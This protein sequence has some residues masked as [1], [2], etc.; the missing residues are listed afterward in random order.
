[1]SL[2]GALA[3]YRARLR[4]RT[5]LRQELLAAVGIGLGVGLLFASQVT[6]TSLNATTEQLTPSVLGH[7]RYELKARSPLG[8]P[9]QM[10]NEVARLPGVRSA[11]PVLEQEVDLSGPRGRELVELLATEPSDLRGVGGMVSLLRLSELGDRARS[12]ARG[13]LA[14]KRAGARQRTPLMVIPESVAH[15]IG[16]DEAGRAVVQ[17]GARTSTVHLIALNSHRALGLAGDSPIAFMPL[18]SA[19]SLTNLE[20]RLSRILVSA[21]SSQ[22]GEVRRGL[23][24]LSTTQASVEPVTV[25]ARVFNQASEPIRKSTQTFAAICAL[26]GFVF[27]Y[28]ATLLTMQLRRRFVGELRRLG[29]TR[30]TIAGSLLIDI[31]VLGATACL[32][33]LALGEVL[34]VVS[35]EG[36]TG[37]LRFAFPVRA[38]RI[39]S[40]QD[41]VLA[42]AAGFLAA[43]V[44]V[45]ASLTLPTGYAPARSDGRAARKPLALLCGG[46]TCLAASGL[47][48]LLSAQLEILGVGLLIVGALALLPPA[49]EMAKTVTT[50]ASEGSGSAARAIAVVELR[51]GTMRTRSVVI[52]AIVAIAV[53]GGVLIEGARA[54]LLGGLHRSA[55]SISSAADLWVTPYGAQNLLA[56][57][58]ITGV[59][60]DSLQNIPGVRSVGT[61]R[62]SF[63]E[64]GNRRVWIVAPSST[65]SSLIAS[66]Q[67]VT[68][69]ASTANAR[70]REGGWTVVSATLARQLHLEVG[71][72]L[73]LPTPVP[74]PLR[75]AALSTNLGWS[76]GTV[77]L[78]TG[79]YKRAM[80][81]S[82]P[83]AFN[84]DLTPG[85]DGNA[86]ARAISRRLAVLGASGL[87]V[88]SADEREREQDAAAGQG[89]NRL[90]QIAFLLLLT[91]VLATVISMTSAI[92]Q[93]RYRFARLK[94]HGAGWQVL[95]RAL[96]WETLIVIGVGGICGAVIGAYGQIVLS[97]ALLDG[98]GY[99]VVFSLRPGVALA[100]L[101]IVTSTAGTAVALTG[102]RVART[103]AG[104]FS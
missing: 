67:M 81:E 8:F 103:A 93:R 10:V 37:F 28:C 89:L 18:G 1:V 45:L 61:F 19:Q 78:D 21:S 86:V 58:P 34:S 50:R 92:S 53:L 87:A 90:T 12:T 3:L 38:E 7:S 100:V 68:G 74:V 22:A 56:T 30:R 66:S 2:I 5:M 46:L 35:F 27:A 102:L 57:V 104:R 97:R 55:A 60:A 79:D 54:G 44:G 41:V 62:S 20:G 32:L 16:A 94:I 31:V 49:L 91:G 25:D 96:L 47:A 39:V 71:Q 26:L 76:P 48:V 23:E 77:M 99:P 11:V 33:G 4:E 70:L 52:A 24:S 75:V 65:A 13:L 14:P 59:A 64:L 85:A 63:L 29:A 83:T 82:A 88:Q 9:Q 15:S 17:V 40:L 6:T 98:F 36:G 51:A 84:V 69:R 80:A 95:W 42:C 101:A 73:E 72:R 43:C